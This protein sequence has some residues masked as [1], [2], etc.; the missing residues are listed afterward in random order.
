MEIKNV[1]IDARGIH[2]QV[3][4]SWTRYL[5][6]NRIMVIDDNTV[7][8]DMQKMA[9]KMACPAG[10]KL[11]ILSCEKAVSRLTD[12]N[13][14]VNDSLMIILINVETL[15]KLKELGYC[16]N[17]VNI[18]NLPSRPNTEEIR[19]TVY[20]TDEEKKIILNVGESGTHFIAQMVPKDISVD[21]IPLLK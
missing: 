14:Y 18:G 9:L 8:N 1:R 16:F 2:G 15:A 17:E 7:K 3:A 6:I 11:S 13:A 20:L 21:F 19:K 5:G 10:V 4:T 12:P